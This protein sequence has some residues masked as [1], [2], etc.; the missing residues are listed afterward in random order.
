MSAADAHI[1]I[2]LVCEEIKPWMC[3]LSTRGE[4]E[5][6]VPIG[7]FLFHLKP[8]KKKK[9]VTL[10]EFLCMSF[11]PCLRLRS[12]HHRLRSN[13]QS[14]PHW[15]HRSLDIWPVGKLGRPT[16]LVL[17]LALDSK[18]HCAL[19]RESNRFNNRIVLISTRNVYESKC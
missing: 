18:S 5:A 13:R 11:H 8:Y 15:P 2:L 1:K 17:M 9:K 4:E 14:Q 3:L 19:R 12:G 6:E 7:M 16:I 10:F